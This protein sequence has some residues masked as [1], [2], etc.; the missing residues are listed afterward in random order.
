M[1]FLSTLFGIDDS[2]KCGA[3]KRRIDPNKGASDDPAYMVQMRID[4]AKTNLG[5]FC[6]KCNINIHYR[7]AK[8]D[9]WRDGPDT[10]TRIKCP[11]CESQLKF[12]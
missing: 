5:I 11:Q 1:S 6:K 4:P 10:Y 8:I 7:C 2:G 12:I 3:C 9:R